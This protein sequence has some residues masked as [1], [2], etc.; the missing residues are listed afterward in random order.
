M[1]TCI[2]KEVSCPICGAVNKKQMWPGIDSQANAE[3]RLRILRETL[4]DWKCPSCGYDAQLLYPCIYHDK[5]RRFLICIVPS[6]CSGQKTIEEFSGKYPQIANIKKRV[7]NSLCEMKEKILL[8]EAGLDDVPAEI[9]KFA[10]AEL[11]EK[12]RGRKV[13]SGFFCAAGKEE[14]YIGFTF[15]LEG[16]DQPITQGTRLSVYREA[17]KIVESTGYRESG[18]F[19]RVDRML[20]EN[21]LEEYQE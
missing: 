17:V 6:G 8:F 19:I 10:L 7:V 9:V 18:E 3:L 13:R 1:S 5:E 11:V 4:F 15:F 21:L 2:S 14:D 12:K 16:S 20:A